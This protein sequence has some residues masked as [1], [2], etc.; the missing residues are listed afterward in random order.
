MGAPHILPSVG[1][2]PGRCSVAAPNS[3]FGVLQSG[4]GGFC[5]TGDPAWASCMQYMCLSHWLSLA[6]EQVSLYFTTAIWTG[7]L[8]KIQFQVSPA[9]AILPASIALSSC[10]SLV[11]LS[12]LVACWL[13]DLLFKNLSFNSLNSTVQW[14]ICHGIPLCALQRFRRFL[15]EPT[16]Q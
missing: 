11:Q 9:R 1:T 4:A 13:M 3:H 7:C 12:T 6:R 8:L 14:L 16:N 2:K 10:A 15:S 5:I